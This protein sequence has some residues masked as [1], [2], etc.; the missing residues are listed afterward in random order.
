[1]PSSFGVRAEERALRKTL[2]LR[3]GRARDHPSART[4]KL[5][6]GGSRVIPPG[7][8]HKH[9]DQLYPL[10]VVILGSP[11]RAA[12]AREVMWRQVHMGACYLS[13]AHIGQTS[14]SCARTWGRGLAQLKRLGLARVVRLHW[15][16]GKEAVNLVDLRMLWWRLVKCLG[17]G[18]SLLE[19]KGGRLWVKM[20]GIWLSGEMLA[21]PA[22]ERPLC[23]PP[24]CPSSSRGS[25]PG[26]QP[27]PQPA[28]FPWRLVPV[29]S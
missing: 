20:A 7:Q 29:V 26:K 14:Q 16:D 21:S 17:R 22:P 28:A 8:F 11:K 12:M 25:G 13:A 2:V 3:E 15:L 6:G 27:S 10:L 1:M 9:F 18:M 5:K 19:R 24:P 23:K 4:P